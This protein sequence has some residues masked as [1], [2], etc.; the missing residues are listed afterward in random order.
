MLK[1]NDHVAVSEANDINNHGHG[2]KH[3]NHSEKG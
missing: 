3:S 2:F 1:E